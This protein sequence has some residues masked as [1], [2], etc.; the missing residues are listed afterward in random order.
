VLVRNVMIEDVTSV[1]PDDTLQH[2]YDLL[3]AKRYDCLPVTSDSKTIV[4]IIQLTDIYEACMKEGP[5]TVLPKLVGA[6]MTT[7]LITIDT[8]DILERAA[9]TMLRRD[10]PMLPV[11]EDGVFKGILNESDIFRAFGEMLGVDSGTT[12]LTLVVPDRKGALA[13]ITEIIR[14][15]GVSISHLATFQSKTFNQYKLV[16]RVE[17]DLAK[18]L[19]ELLDQHGY[20]VLH[21]AND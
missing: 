6:F 9:K 12:R 3:K 19:V 17:T 15:A 21:I 8:D 16:V 11:V 20:K 18:P 13:R 2:A 10:I 14:N 5:Q 7:D 4:G 1:S